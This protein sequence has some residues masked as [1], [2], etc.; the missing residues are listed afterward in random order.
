[1]YGSLA[2]LL[3]ITWGGLAVLLLA[4]GLRTKGEAEKRRR[5]RRR[6]KEG[7]RGSTGGEEKKKKKKRF[8]RRV[9]LMGKKR[10]KE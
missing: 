1:M 5:R 7:D 9:F 8:G 6:K 3:Y 2:L 10:E 4:E